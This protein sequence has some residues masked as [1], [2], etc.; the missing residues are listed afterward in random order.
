MRSAVARHLKWRGTKR[1]LFEINMC[2]YL[3][4]GYYFVHNFLIYF[5]K[6]NIS[7]LTDP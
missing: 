3:A 4:K 2:S 6:K 5:A 1:F 7:S